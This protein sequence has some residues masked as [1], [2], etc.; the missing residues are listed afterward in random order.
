MSSAAPQKPSPLGLR[1]AKQSPEHGRAVERVQLGTRDRFRLPED[2]PVLV[3]QLTCTNGSCPPLQT[4]VAFWTETGE[5]HHFKV[6]KPIEALVAGD[7][8]S[9]W[10]DD[11]LFT[12]GGSGAAGCC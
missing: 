1:R 5:R 7:I 10:L 6:L 3:S 4:V 8:P 12:A 2:A 11:M 9:E